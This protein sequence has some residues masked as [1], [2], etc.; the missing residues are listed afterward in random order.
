MTGVTNW[1][2]SIEEQLLNLQDINNQFA[3]FG[4]NKTL[5]IANELSKAKD[6]NERQ[7]RV[8]IQ[9]QEEIE[10]NESLIHQ[11]PKIVDLQSELANLKEEQK[12]FYKTNSVNAQRIVSLID[13]VQ[14][15]QTELAQLKTERDTL[16][17]TSS[18]MT[19]KVKD[20]EELIN[21][22]DRVIQILRDELQAHQLELVQR[23]SQLE[24]A[25]SKVKELENENQD[26]IRRWISEKEK[27]AQKI[28]EVNEFV[29]TT[30]K[31]KDSMSNRVFS[32]FK[33][34]S[35]ASALEEEE[36]A[37]PSTSLLPT[38][39][40]KQFKKVHDD[41]IN[42]MGIS[43]DGMLLATGGNDKKLVI[44]DIRSGTPKAILSGSLQ[45]IMSVAFNRSGDMVLASSNDNSTKIWD[46]NSKRIIHIFNGHLQKIY[47]SKFID[48]ST[49]IWDLVKGYCT[50]TIFTM[51][52]CNDL[53]ILS[54]DGSLIGSG[55]LDNNLR[56]W[57]SKSG[58]SVKEI[59]GI[60]FGQITSVQ[61]SPDYRKVMTTSRDNTIK[62]MDTRMYMTLSTCMALG[63]KV[64]SNWSKSC[65]SSD[66]KYVASGSSDGN[67]YIWRDSELIST[68]S[69][70][71]AGVCSVL[72]SPNGGSTL[73]SA[74][75]KDK[76]VNE[77]GNEM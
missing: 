21:E 76:V 31:T 75:D 11:H 9:K 40:K 39:L 1:E 35:K 47:S 7:G 64:S 43:S 54:P 30:L 3:F 60:H 53:S 70:H 67:I 27:E 10:K 44:H 15:L 52:S 33:G 28:N 19:V 65:F 36:I 69:K 66:G 51:S 6:E 46:L 20:L 71:S 58:K 72:W 55:H 5:K 23:E 22:K 62:I 29:E 48:S 38:V 32:L 59:S 42:C 18:Q 49:I 56:I 74:S 50:K 68:L 77:W 14:S 61:V 63:F 13:N 25:Q 24:S 17:K 41:D 2:R 57:D 73:F 37:P 26:L 12:D 8:I 34:S 45:A 16:Q 4:D